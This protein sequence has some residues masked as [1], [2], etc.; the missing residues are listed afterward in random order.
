MTSLKV[1]VVG[2]DELS[3]A[4]ILEILSHEPSFEV[5]AQAESVVEAITYTYLMYPDLVFLY[6]GT[7]YLNAADVLNGI[8]RVVP[9]TNIVLIWQSAIESFENY[10]YA[11]DTDG[12]IHTG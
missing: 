11:A 7:P 12:F 4:T 5:I 10:D 8:K 2:A 9:G 6:V 3:G 1:L